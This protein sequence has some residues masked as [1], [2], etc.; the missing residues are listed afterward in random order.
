MLSYYLV[1]EMSLA[2]CVA[3]NSWFRNVNLLHDIWL[4]HCVGALGMQPM[5]QEMSLAHCV[6]VNSWFRNANL[7]HDTCCPIV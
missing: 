4:P 7:Q 6:V 1:Q 5:V 2:H 3:V